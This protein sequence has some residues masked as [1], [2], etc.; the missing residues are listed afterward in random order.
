MVTGLDIWK[1]AIVKLQNKYQL[2]AFMINVT[3]NTLT[4]WLHRDKKILMLSCLFIIHHLN[5]FKNNKGFMKILVYS[6]VTGII[7]RFM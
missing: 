3:I 7:I 4:E 5:T 6:S 1:R 2:R